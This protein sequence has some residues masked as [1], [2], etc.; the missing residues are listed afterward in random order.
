MPSAVLDIVFKTMQ[1]GTGGKAAAAELKE[2]KGVVGELSSGFGVFNIANV[3][4]L[5]AVTAIGAAVA[6]SVNNWQDYAQEIRQMSALTGTGVEE[7][8]RLVQAFD[9]L[10]ITQEQV[11]TVMQ[12]AA[13]KGFV[14]SIENVAQLADKYNGLSTQEEKNKLL[15]DELG[16]S[17]LQLAKAM[18]EGGDAI[19]AAADAQA[20][21]LIVTEQAIRDS[22]NLRVAQDMLGDAQTNLSNSLAMKLVPIQA[23]L[24]YN[25]AKTAESASWTRAEYD[26]LAASGVTVGANGAIINGHLQYQEE[27]ARRAAL[28]LLDYN[29]SMDVGA[30]VTNAMATAAQGAATALADESTQMSA[31]TTDMKAYSNQ[32]LFQIST[33]GL[34]AATKL[35]VAEALGLVDEHTKAARE[36]AEIY[37]KEFADGTITAEEYALR[38]GGIANI[39]AGINS[40]TV[41]VVIN[42]RTN[43]STTNQAYTGGYVDPGTGS[44]YGGNS[45]SV[46]QSTGQ[47]LAGTS[48]VSVGP[49]YVNSPTT[50]QAM[51]AQLRY[52]L[53]RV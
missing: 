15:T 32:L 13:R 47:S 24:T 52:A 44:N 16:R 21:G 23:E 19:R 28:A 4:A 27:L 38:L 18:K 51:M 50:L 22:E 26:K 42:I 37:R 3:T 12:S 30:G 40:K 43:Y 5:G 1:Q 8:S 48:A 36:A 49:V 6:Q 35:K 25:L 39:L 20:A 29:S 41:D 34:D 17:G 53:P 9:D 31:L 11:S 10:G 7:T 33:E 45:N 2:L 14:M 46:G